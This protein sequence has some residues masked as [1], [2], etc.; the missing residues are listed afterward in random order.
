M[1]SR[2]SLR[3]LKRTDFDWLHGLYADPE[4][5]RYM[6]HGAHTLPEQTMA[7]ME[8][9]FSGDNAAFVLLEKE[10]GK[11]V[12]YI[13]MTESNETPGEYSITIMIERAFSGKGYAAEG[14]RALIDDVRTKGKAALLSAY[15][16][17]K[18]IASW[19]T[20]EKCGFVKVSEFPIQDGMRL[21]IYHL[22]L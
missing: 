18:N 16:I 1:E 14:L 5:A 6:R 11:K 15:I 22:K 8:R 20:A 9:Y 13:S 21:F 3:P 12:G 4:L 7:L 10:S 2:L 19:K 17:D